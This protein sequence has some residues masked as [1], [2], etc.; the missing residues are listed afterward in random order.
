MEV[1]LAKRHPHKIVVLQQLLPACWKG[2]IVLQDLALRFTHSGLTNQF[3]RAWQLQSDELTELEEKVWELGGE[4]DPE[5]YMKEG[6][7]TNV[8]DEPIDPLSLNRM[9]LLHSINHLTHL[10]HVYTEVKRTTLPFDVRMILQR[11]QLR[12]REILGH[13]T[14][15]Y[16]TYPFSR[17]AL[18]N[19]SLPEREEEANERAGL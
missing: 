5:S 3:I 8:E 14:S 12:T 18:V 6:K 2:V 10:I 17:F 15:L 11:H 19:T 13:L 16:A 7:S 9:L 1:S 4:T